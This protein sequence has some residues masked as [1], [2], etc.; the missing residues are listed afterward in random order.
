MKIY[1]KRGDAGQTSLV[2]GGDFSKD[3][4]RVQ[5]YGTVDELNSFL[6]LA[7]SFM[8]GSSQEAQALSRVQEQLFVLGAELA[9]IQSGAKGSS[10]YLREDAVT[11]LETQIDQWEKSLP[12]LKH[13]ILPGGASTGAT[14]HLA[15]TVCRRAERILVALHHQEAQRSEILQ[16][17]NRLSDWLFVLA[18]HCNE[19]SGQ[20]ETPWM[21]LDTKK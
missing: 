16:Y 20:T 3:H 11:A 7:L 12:Q 1:T 19:L 2:G 8:E 10:G 17:L 13:F 9:T 15:R 14:L 21:G 18:R 5:A 4:L 6:G